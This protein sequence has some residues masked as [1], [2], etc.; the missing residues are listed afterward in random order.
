MTKVGK[1]PDNSGL[2]LLEGFPKGVTSITSSE[3]ITRK[4]E[5]IKLLTCDLQYDPAA[6]GRRDPVGCY[7][8]VGAAVPPGHGGQAHH[9]A[10]HRWRVPARPDH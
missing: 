4:I 8:E 10:L 1:I 2:F 3:D 6:D 5:T 7:T 9:L